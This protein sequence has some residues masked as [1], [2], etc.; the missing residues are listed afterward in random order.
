MRP[1][2]TGDDTTDAMADR[3]V[4]ST[5]G[6]PN[7]TPPTGMLSRMLSKF[8]FSP[9]KTD[10]TPFVP[11]CVTVTDLEESFMR[12]MN[13]VAVKLVEITN[14]L[15]SS[16]ITNDNNATKLGNLIDVVDTQGK[17][18]ANIENR[19]KVLEARGDLADEVEE[20]IEELAKGRLLL[21]PSYIMFMPKLNRL[22]GKA[23]KTI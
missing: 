4:D 9:E 7:K 11:N 23:R 2:D 21:T 13:S 15:N 10:D 5:T 19:L 20:R 17:K 8:V 6:S 1:L 12:K 14:H 22:K 18:L 16:T 3:S